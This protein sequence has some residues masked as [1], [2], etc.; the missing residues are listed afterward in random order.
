MTSITHPISTLNKLQTVILLRWLLIIATSYLMLFSRPLQQTPAAVPRHLLPPRAPQAV[1]TVA[2]QEFGFRMRR[3][4]SRQ[5]LAGVHPHAGEIL[6][7]AVGGIER[8]FQSGIWY[9]FSLR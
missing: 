6:L 5:Q 9:S 3:R 2:P 7:Q 8:D 1:G 4:Q